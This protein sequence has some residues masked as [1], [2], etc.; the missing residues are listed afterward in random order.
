MGRRHLVTFALGLVWITAVHG[1][2]QSAMGAPDG[3]SSG[4]SGAAFDAGGDAGS[5]AGFAGDASA[6][7]P[8]SGTFTCVVVMTRMGVG[9]CDHP[10]L[11]GCHYKPSFDMQISGDSV[12]LPGNF[13]CV[14]T[15]DAGPQGQGGYF[16]CYV[17]GSA[18]VIASPDPDGGCPPPPAVCAN[19]GWTIFPPGIPT[20]CPVVLD[21]GEFCAAI[22]DYSAGAWWGGQQFQAVCQ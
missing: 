1:C 13:S 7:W 22:G 11:P 5:D 2:R 21:A 19:V 12:T 3:G 17:T 18:W 14:G 20:P 6:A 16:T 10:G 9:F 4:D 15:W 8:P